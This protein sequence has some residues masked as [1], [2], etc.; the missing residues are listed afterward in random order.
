MPDVSAVFVEQGEN[1]LAISTA[2][3]LT[4]LSRLS[5]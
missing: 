2:G 1:G 5:H 3:K 4:G